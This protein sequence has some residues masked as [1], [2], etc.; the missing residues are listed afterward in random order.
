MSA[1]NLIAWGIAS[2]LL[3]VGTGQAAQSDLIASGTGFFVNSDGWLVT[4]AHVL[5]GCVS[6]TVVGRGDTSEWKN[7]EL[8]DLAVIHSPGVAPAIISVR[9]TPARLGEDVAALGYPLAPVLSSSV[10]ITTGNVNS[11]LGIGDDTRYLQISTPIQPGNSGGPLVDQSGSLIGITAATLR[12]GATG[13]VSVTPQNVNFAVRASLLAL[14]LQSRSVE[15]QA[16]EAIGPILST[17]DLADKIAPATAQILCHGSAPVFVTIQ[18]TV[19]TDKGSETIPGTLEDAT[20][21]AK[22]FAYGYHAAWSSDNAAAFVYMNS[23]YSGQ[24]IYYGKMQSAVDVIEEKRRFADRW[25]VRTYSI[26]D[27]SLSAQC[28]GSICAIN[29]VLDW[30]VRSEKR[31]KTAA[32]IA[33]FFMSVDV[34]RGVVLRE[35]GSVIR[36]ARADV[37]SL[38][39]RWYKENGR[40]RGGAGDDTDSLE[41]CD[42]RTALDGELAKAGWCYGHKDDYGYQMKWHVCD[43]ASLR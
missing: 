32:G 36:P 41:A 25:P 15:F 33:D 23:A 9:N 16:A 29:G 40:C 8:N 3:L 43:A 10:K 39:A 27:G 18:P 17:A 7:D 12:E 22:A 14:F 5:K 20:Q 4:N 11:L 37:K 26:R 6:V 13:D 42:R 1:G 34:D 19:P 30:Q 28:V 21:K 24:V 35:S 2:V 38:L 31:Q